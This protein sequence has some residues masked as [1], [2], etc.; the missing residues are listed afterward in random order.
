MARQEVFK[1]ASRFVPIIF[2]L[3]VVIMLSINIMKI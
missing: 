2:G 1:G 3:S